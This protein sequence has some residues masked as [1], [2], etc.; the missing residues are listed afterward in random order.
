MTPTPLT[1]SARVAGILGGLCWLAR[2]VLDGTGAPAPAVDGLYWGGLA[3]LA[4]A[5]LAIGAGLVSGIATLRVLVAVCLGVMAWSLLEFLRGQYADARVDAVA[6]VVV[7]LGCAAGVARR[8]P[9]APATAAPATPAAP[10]AS[11]HRARRGPSSPA[12]RRR[13]PA[14]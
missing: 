8:R 7:A 6:G 9:T 3:L 1:V 13:S 4:V 14:R 12:G 5:L 11:G 10:A 2:A